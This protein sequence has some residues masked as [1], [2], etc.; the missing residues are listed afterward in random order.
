MV[1]LDALRDHVGAGPSDDVLEGLLAAALE[2]IDLRYG[3]AT[4]TYR[5][6]VRPFG[7]WVR[8][9]I[10]ASAVSTVIE[11]T[12]ALETADYALWPGGK[13]VRRLHDLD[14]SDWTGMVD[15]TY[16]PL[17][18]AAERDRV[19]LGLVKVD[20][21]YHPGLTSIT[22]GPWSESYSQA[23]DSHAQAREAVL[24]SL[25]PATVGVW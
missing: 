8:L 20:L 23:S 3:P 4:E 19:A 15:I 18:E 24:R 16:R 21:A 11:G 25:R 6:Y 1:D 14:P 22:V 13:Y 10:R 17:S 12:S 5:E 9:G 7:Q 2:A